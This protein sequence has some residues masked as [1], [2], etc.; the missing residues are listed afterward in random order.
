MISEK[1]E[2][3]GEAT[4]RRFDANVAALALEE[5]LDIC[6]ANDRNLDTVGCK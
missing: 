4:S 3:E 2:G 5:T 1:W 6:G